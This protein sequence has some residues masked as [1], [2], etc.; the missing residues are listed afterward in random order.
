[1]LICLL[2]SRLADSCTARVEELFALTVFG[3][4]LCR[5]QLR[6]GLKRFMSDATA[7]VTMHHIAASARV[8]IHHA[9]LPFSF[10]WGLLG[11]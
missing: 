10:H 8:I 7:L 11:T 6:G 5:L 2:Y 3:F 4:Q 9:Q 1:M